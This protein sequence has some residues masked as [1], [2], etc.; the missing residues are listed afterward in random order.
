MPRGQKRPQKEILTEQLAKTKDRLEKAQNIVKESKEE[1]KSLEKQLKEI[2]MD[3]LKELME[4]N[5]VSVEELKGL[6]N[7]PE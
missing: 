2:E 4:Q 5:N 3:E 7:K 6:L 1:I